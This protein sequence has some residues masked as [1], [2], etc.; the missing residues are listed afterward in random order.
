[1]ESSDIQPWLFRTK[2]YEG[3]SI[4]HYLGR[5]RRA[6][7]LTPTG[8]GKATGLGGAIAPWEKFR[9]NP[10]PS[11]MELEKLAQ[12]V[13]IDVSRLREMLPPPE[14]GMKM[15]P[16][17]LYGACCGEM[18]CHRIEWQLKTTEFCSK[19]G[20]TL[21]SECSTCGS[22]FAFPAL[23]VD[24]LCQRCFTAFGEMVQYQKLA[25]KS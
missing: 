9:F 19:H 21:L 11:K 10:P 2:P 16:I 6:N 8:L 20:L 14:I 25:Q 18:L 1:M 23:W 17:R 12:V 7:N 5:F 15:N 24:G 22:R 3:E 4:S 13:K